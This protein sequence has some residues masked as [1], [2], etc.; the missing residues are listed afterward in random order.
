MTGK[1]KMVC[2]LPKRVLRQ[3]GYV[4]TVPRPHTSIGPLDPAEVAI[5]F[6]EFVVHVLSQQE[7]GESIPE[8]KDWMHS[9]GYI[10]WFYHVSHPLI[11]GPAPV[12]EYVD[13]RHVY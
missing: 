3:Y 13:P 5:A 12:P 9:N 7:R 8:D 2:H 6:L 4:Q 11:V 10:K 1:Q